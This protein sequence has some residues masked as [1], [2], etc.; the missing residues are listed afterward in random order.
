[1]P[2]E[3]RELVGKWLHSHEEDTKT[4]KVY[5]RSGFGFPPS[6]GRE[7]YE[8]RADHSATY[9]GIAP[10]NGQTREPCS[11]LL[12][13]DTGREIVMMSARDREWGLHIVSLSRDRLVLR[14]P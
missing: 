9:I 8:F 1:M 2:D 13:E 6:R 12:R 11:W 4:E 5:R 7:G 10:V 14:R 3:L